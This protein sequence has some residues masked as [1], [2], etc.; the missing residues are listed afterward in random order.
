MKTNMRFTVSVLCTAFLLPLAGS[1]YASDPSFLGIEIGKPL[2]VRECG[3]FVSGETG[4]ICFQFTIDKTNIKR[5][6][7]LPKLGFE[8]ELN[9][10]LDGNAVDAVSLTTENAN[11]PK[12]LHLLDIRYGEPKTIGNTGRRVWF[13]NSLAVVLGNAT[14][15]IQGQL[16]LTATSRQEFEHMQAQQ[17]EVDT[18]NKQE[19]N[20]AAMRF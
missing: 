4:L 19:V 6:W 11:M 7:A 10:Y 5:L 1:A 15:W 16:Q 8:Y 20:R 17:Q 18:K 2:D 14:D 9:A 3:P 12:L 13:G